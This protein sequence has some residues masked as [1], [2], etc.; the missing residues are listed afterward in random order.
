MR[1]VEPYRYPLARTN[2]RPLPPDFCGPIDVWDIDKTYL[3]TEFERWR[4]LVRTAFETAI[5][6]RARPGIV[7]LLRALRRGPVPGAPRTPLYFVS[8]S[9]PELRT[10]LQG[11][12]LLD[13]VEW[14]GMAFK[15]YRSLLRARRWRELRRHVPYKLTALLEYRAEWPPGAREW[16][17]GDDAE[18]DPLVYSLY[19]EIRAGA[20]S[21]DS[22]EE[23][24]ARAEVGARDRRAIRDLAARA[25]EVA[26]PPPGGAGSVEAIYI[27]RV[28][29]NPPFDATAFARITPVADAAD[30]ARRLLARGRILESDVEAVVRDMS[31]R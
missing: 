24:L 16:L 23:A 29:A 30:L 19:A 14:D 5:D 17:Y 4:D 1:A 20:L 28:A 3:E 6:K 15:D 18:T 12:M 31:A 8:A 22:L 2:D 27:F 25:Q 13:G 11:K 7:P 9:P 26:P 21:G 10:V